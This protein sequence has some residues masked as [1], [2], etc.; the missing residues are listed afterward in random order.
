MKEAVEGK[1]YWVEYDENACAWL[2]DLATNER[3]PLEHGDILVIA[4]RRKP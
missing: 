2:V 3:I 1:E 4:K